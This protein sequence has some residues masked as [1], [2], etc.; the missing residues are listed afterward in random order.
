M[1]GRLTGVARLVSPASA[2]GTGDA[3]RNT[4]INDSGKWTH[5]RHE[6][7]SALLPITT[8]CLFGIREQ[9][10]MLRVLNGVN[11]RDSLLRPRPTVGLRSVVQQLCPFDE[12]SRVYRVGKQAVRL[13]CKA[14]SLAVCASVLRVC[15]NVSRFPPSTS[16]TR[17]DG[18]AAGVS[19][20]VGTG[21]MT[22]SRM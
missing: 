3:A 17:G 5:C 22:G 2:D 7:H 13:P 1:C 12:T 18:V 4:R 19:R 10:H 15:V 20:C 21:I 11:P 9:E 16:R 8:T 14:T 6:D